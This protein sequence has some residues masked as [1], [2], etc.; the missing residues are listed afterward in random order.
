MRIPGEWY[1]CDDGYI[2]P[3]IRG[4]VRTAGGVWEPAP[5]LID[6]GADRTVLC[7]A[8]LH[9]LGLE[10]IDT[11][12]PLGGIGGVARSVT[13]STLLRFPISA[14]GLA[15]FRGEYAAFTELETLDMSVLGRDLLDLFAVI[16]D[17]PGNTVALIRAN[18]RYSIESV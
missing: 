2:R 12:A 14:G 18:D 15:Q 7:A 13:V 17:R 9:L 5:F 3:V 6:T 8:I 1:E 16:I 10:P 4:E 11:D